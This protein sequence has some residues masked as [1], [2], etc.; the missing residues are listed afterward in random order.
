MKVRYGAQS[1][2]GLKREVNQDCYGIAEALP[3][4]RQD[5]LLVVCDGMGGHMAGEVASR[6][7]VSAL[8]AHYYATA[9]EDR[10]AL[11]PAALVAANRQVYEQGRGT[12]GTTS[13]VA[14][15]LGD[16]LH[17]ANVGDS[18]AYLLR[19]GQLRQL[20]QDHSFVAEQVAAG[21]LTP[22]QA[23]VSAHRNMITRAL[24]H[25]ADVQV[26]LFPPLTLQPGDSVILSTDGMHGLVEDS[27]I[28]GV[29]S[30]LLPEAAVEQL[31]QMA[32]AR[33]GTDNITVVIAQVVP[34]EEPLDAPAAGSL[35]V[36]QPLPVQP[37]P[38]PDV[39][40]APAT[41]DAP[42][43]AAAAG[44]RPLTQRGAL[45]A[46][47]ALLL[48][49][50]VGA[51]AFRFSPAGGGGAPPPQLVASATA[52]LTPT[53]ATPSPTTGTVTPTRTP[54]ETPTR[55]ATPT[56]TATPVPPPVDEP[57]GAASDVWPG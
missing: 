55:T 37:P 38:P 33:G 47:A 19:D 25:Q 14:L 7:G 29:V 56:A 22:E 4:E 54:T 31:V 24:G 30:T 11:L 17:V 53:S 44:E 20:S 21:L 2:L 32:N 3:S 40:D 13:V 50:A 48:L 23:R 52:T 43:P 35:P 16:Q 36:T 10:R 49:L 5:R 27:E 39:P 57:A 26:D 41:P 42:T 18:R 51:L 8:L 28:A 34:P 45:L 1:D 12:M 9:Q 6:L 46:L 15:L